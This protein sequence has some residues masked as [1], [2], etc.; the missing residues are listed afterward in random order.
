MIQKAEKR[1]PHPD[2]RPCLRE[3]CSGTIPY[4]VRKDKR[5]CSDACRT[6]FHNPQR[7]GLDPEVVRINKILQ[8]NFEIMAEVYSN[9]K[10]HTIDR[11]AIMRMGFSFDYFT[12]VYK[13]FKYCYFYGYAENNNKVSIVRGFD[14][15]VKKR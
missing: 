10:T 5:F 15:I 7:Q 8:T 14:D 11:D 1:K 13:N 9:P 12:Q 2:D 3:G 4:N 6:A